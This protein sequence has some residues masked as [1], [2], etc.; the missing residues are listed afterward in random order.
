M[1]IEDFLGLTEEE[2]NKRKEEVIRKIP[3]FPGI[4]YLRT[5][6]EQFKVQPWPFVMYLAYWAPNLLKEGLECYRDYDGAESAHN[7]VEQMKEDY[8]IWKVVEDLEKKY[9]EKP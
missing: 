9:P 8:I 7:I 4:K 6:V 5:R 2:I 1:A 3:T